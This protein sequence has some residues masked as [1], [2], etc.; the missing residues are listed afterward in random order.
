MNNPENQKWL[1]KILSKTI[2]SEKPQANF[3]QWKEQHP[4]AVEMLTSRTQYTHKNP[5]RI[6]NLMSQRDLFLI[7]EIN[8]S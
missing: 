8:I 1:D 7:R 3:E 4:R 5:L 2:G 6:G